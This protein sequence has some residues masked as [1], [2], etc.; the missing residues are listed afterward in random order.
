MMTR[1][2]LA[3]ASLLVLSASSAASP[4]EVPR[5]NDPEKPVVLVPAKDGF[6]GKEHLLLSVDN[7]SEEPISVQGTLQLDRSEGDGT[8]TPVFTMRVAT[9]CPPGDARQTPSP[10]CVTLPPRTRWALPPW[11]FYGAGLD[12]CPPRPPGVRA[13]KGIYRATLLPCPSA[14]ATGAQAKMTPAVVYLTWE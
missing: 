3:L 10:A 2:R 13:F 9:A 7:R 11:D 1:G 12:Q 14:K 6:R 5:Q 8:W 4:P